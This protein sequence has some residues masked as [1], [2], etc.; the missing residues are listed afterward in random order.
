[1]R[2]KRTGEEKEKRTRKIRLLFP[3]DFTI[4]SRTEM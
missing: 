3:P 2:E 1:M 4:L